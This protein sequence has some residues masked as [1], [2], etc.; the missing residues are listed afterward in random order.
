MIR[1]TVG[2]LQSRYDLKLD[3]IKNKNIDVSIL[4]QSDRVVIDRESK[5]QSVTRRVNGLRSGSLLHL[6]NVNISTDGILH[7][8]HL[9]VIL[10]RVFL[11]VT[12][13]S[14]FFVSDALSL[15]ILICYVIALQILF[16]NTLTNGFNGR[17]IKD[18]L[19]RRI[20]PLKSLIR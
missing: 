17:H 5:K 8:K 9:I 7:S 13:R 3:Q 12:T 16:T 6:C 1:V 20:I 2:K 19:H 11:F 10:Y 15:V 4:P 14:S 18:P